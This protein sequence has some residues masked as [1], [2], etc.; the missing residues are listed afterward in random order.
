MYQV[1]TIVCFII[2]CFIY[3]LAIIPLAFTNIVEYIKNKEMKKNL[4]YNTTTKQTL[5][6]YFPKNL[7]R[8]KNK[9]YHVVIYISGGVWI[10][11]NKLTSIFI[12]ERFTDS[13]IIFVSI[14]YRNFPFGTIEHMM[15]DLMNAY[16]YVINYFNLEQIFVDDY[17][18]LGHSAGAHIML[19]CTIYKGLRAGSFYSVGGIYNLVEQTKDF[20]KIGLTSSLFNH[21]MNKNLLKYSPYLTFDQVKISTGTSRTLHIIHADDDYCTHY[22]Y[23][24]QFHKKFSS[25]TRFVTCKDYRHNEVIFESPCIGNYQVIDYIIREVLRTGVK[26]RNTSSNEILYD[27]F[28]KSSNEISRD[29]S[30]KSSNK[31]LYKE[32]EETDSKEII[33]DKKLSSKQKIILDWLHL[34]N[35][36]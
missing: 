29:S 1:Y 11:G 15:N 21:I 32:F 28:N 6:I 3:G 8:S 35:P 36:F 31:I 27:S 17:H 34:F 18:F 26:N 16:K 14:N 23:A 20:H 19:L 5:D 2:W 33:L 10:F 12:H 25:T 4:V 9:K 13:D 24:A 7:T 30:N 22:K